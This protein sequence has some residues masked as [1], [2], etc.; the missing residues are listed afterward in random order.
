MLVSDF[1][2][3]LPDELIAQD[4]APRGAARLLV[5][6]RAT[7]RTHQAMVGD[8]PSY[9]RAGDLLVVNDTR[10]FAARLLG[11]RVPSGGA[12][13][14]LLLSR[15]AP[16]DS[17][18]IT[19]DA[20]VHPGQKLKPGAIVRFDAADGSGMALI[21]EILERKYFGRRR[22]RLQLG[23][24]GSAGSTGSAVLRVL[25]VRWTWPG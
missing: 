24:A 25:P 21:G 8:L 5:V 23:S 7:G 9:L 13:E 12:V 3:D 19:C 22:I 15:P 11:V 6:E 17:G 10:V 20:L 14:C 1:D 4:P 16:D 18:A 2:F